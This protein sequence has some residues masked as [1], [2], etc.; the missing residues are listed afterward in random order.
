M[1]R[2]MHQDMPRTIEKQKQDLTAE[3]A[4]IEKLQ[5]QEE[6]MRSEIETLRSQVSAVQHSRNE[7]RTEREFY[8]DKSKSHAKAIDQ[9]QQRIAVMA[10]LETT[11]QKRLTDANAIWNKKLIEMD[12]DCRAK[13]QS[14]E[15]ALKVSWF[16]THVSVY[17]VCALF[18]FHPVPF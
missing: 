7:E 3:R 9:L 6:K 17:N 16:H 4:T 10:E 1:P 13:L 14:A 15:E 12:E 11:C 2:S 18:L 5:N 8:E